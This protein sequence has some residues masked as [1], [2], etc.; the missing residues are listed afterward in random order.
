MIRLTFLLLLFVNFQSIS[1]KLPV[2][3]NGVIV[4]SNEVV[5]C[6]QVAV[7]A[8]HDIVLYKSG[9]KVD[10]YPAHRVLN[11][12][13]YDQRAAINRKF[14]SVAQYRQNIEEYKLYEVVLRGELTVLRKEK[15]Y[16]RSQ[17]NDFAYYIKYKDKILPLKQFRNK[18]FP[19]MR[20]NNDLSL[21]MKREH[22]NPNLAKDA[23]LL[24]E[25]YNELVMG[26]NSLAKTNSVIMGKGL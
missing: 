25:F 1:A 22:L 23:I 17:H 15:M 16:A 3:Y 26:S 12:F 20:S 18:I 9:E 4:L 24:I 11:I 19:S 8:N 5:L 10:V 21:F 2:W 13:F 6:G 14:I 7:H